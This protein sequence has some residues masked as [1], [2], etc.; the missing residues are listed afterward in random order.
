MKNKIKVICIFLIFMT[1]CSAFSAFADVGHYAVFD[2]AAEKITVSGKLDLSFSGSEISAE[3]VSRQG[4]NVKNSV[5]TNVNSYGGYTLTMDFNGVSEDYYIKIFADNSYL[6]ETDIKRTDKTAISAQMSTDERIIYVQGYKGAQYGGDDVSI[7]FL[8]NGT[9]PDS[10]TLSDIGHIGYSKTDKDGKYSYKFTFD[11]NTEEYCLYTKIGVVVEKPIIGIASGDKYTVDVN[12]VN[13]SG[14]EFDISEDVTGRIKGYIE[15]QYSSEEPLDIIEVFYDEN[16]RMISCKTDSSVTMKFDSREI[17]ESEALSGKIPKDTAFIKFFVWSGKNK[18]KPMTDGKV[19]SSSSGGKRIIFVA[20]WGNDFND[21]SEEAPLA[22]LE[23]ARLKVRHIKET[24]GL[25]KGGIEVCLRGGIYKMTAPVKFTEE[26]GG[27]TD[28][29]VVY[30]ACDG[31]KPVLSGGVYIDGSDFYKVSDSN[32]INRIG[33]ENAQNVYCVDLKAYGILEYGGQNRLGIDANGRGANVEVFYNDVAMDTARWPNRQNGKDEYLIMGSVLSNPE[34][35]S[36]DDKAGVLPKFKYLD[37]RIEGWQSYDDVMVEGFLPYGYCYDGRTVTAIDKENNVLT[38][39]SAF[40][41]GGLRNGARYLYTNVFDEL[42]NDNEY[43][44]DKKTGMLYIYSTQNPKNAKIGISVL[45]GAYSDAMIE[46]EDTSNLIFD[47]LTVTLCRISGIVIN[48]GENNLV[49]NCTVKNIGLTGI[50]IGSGTKVACLSAN[51]IN[52]THSI[53][54][55]E[56]YNNGVESCE[57]FNAGMMGVYVA[58]GDRVNLI[59]CNHFVKNTVIH[60]CSRYSKYFQLAVLYGM[61]IEFSHNELYNAP[62]S[63]LQF[64]GNDIKIKYNDFHA[65]ATEVNDYGMLYSCAYGASIQTGTEISYNYFHDVPSDP[66]PSMHIYDS[67][68]NPIPFRLGI[69]NDGGNPFLEVHHN[70]FADI[71]IGGCSIGGWENNWNDNIFINVSIPLMLQFQP[72]LYNMILDR[73]TLTLNENYDIF[74][75]LTTKEFNFFDLDGVWNEKYPIVKETKNKMAN[76]GLDVCLPNCDIKNNVSVFYS[77][78][79]KQKSEGIYMYTWYATEYYTYDELFK[80]VRRENNLST[81]ED[82]GFYDIVNKNYNIKSNSKIFETH[83]S[84]KSINLDDV[85]PQK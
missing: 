43:Y 76:M 66:T 69:Y 2:A 44:I 29:P 15:N 27:T 17:F 67:D 71:P 77:N 65:L 60:D 54:Y 22:T 18:M 24:V 23:G 84:L 73:K 81:T 79:E 55:K 12:I 37:E 50:I 10:Y 26:D 33:Q 46:T 32:I 31:E 59:P 75:M 51:G 52:F 72:N 34:Y 42:D 14:S 4:G 56:A 25:P 62:V 36:A 78:P 1:V 53:P 82:I 74:D 40:H 83:P 16:K 57:I 39:E 20:P 85:G 45:D 11:G 68:G 3:L 19:Y 5:K 30:K 7:L 13:S 28:S 70:V 61:G 80:N 8:K 63:G 49:K 47:G 9:T 58:G 41:Q 35:G 38:L 64:Y 21:G 6:A 48:G